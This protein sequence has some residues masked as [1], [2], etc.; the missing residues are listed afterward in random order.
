MTDKELLQALN[1]FVRLG[2][3]LDAEAKRRYGEQGFLFH[4]A[5]G[6]LHIMAGDAD[7]GFDS[8]LARQAYIRISAGISADWGAGAW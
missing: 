6:T 1:R 2:N 3:A 8:A 7:R 4:E 5:E